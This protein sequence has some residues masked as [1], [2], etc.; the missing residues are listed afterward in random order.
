[1]Q[2]VIMLVCKLA[3]SCMR[4]D[5]L[6]VEN[7]KITAAAANDSANAVAAAMTDVNTNADFV[8]D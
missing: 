1:M 7:A 3:R 2:S 6:A 5:A 4:R 8:K